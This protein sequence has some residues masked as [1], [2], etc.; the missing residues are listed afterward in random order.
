M[1]N[2][3]RDMFVIIMMNGG[4][5]YGRNREFDLVNFK[6]Y[7][8]ICARTPSWCSTFS[9]CDQWSIVDTISSFKDDIAVV[10]KI[11]D[12]L[13]HNC[14]GSRRRILLLLLISC[15]RISVEPLEGH[16]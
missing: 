7:A 9:L 11:S 6:Q 13:S 3:M 8:L 15:P 12:D 14:R 2:L 1:M 5:I 16:F 4:R 10:V